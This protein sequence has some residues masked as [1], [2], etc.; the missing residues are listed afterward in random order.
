MGHR[1]SMKSLELPPLPEK[2]IWL[3]AYPGAD[4]KKL[5]GERG[6]PTQVSAM[7]IVLAILL[8]FVLQKQTKDSYFRKPHAHGFPTFLGA[9]QDT[10]TCLDAWAE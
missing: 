10:W 1:V 5:S 3:T 9:A 8:S 7:R 6:K 2:F 4:S